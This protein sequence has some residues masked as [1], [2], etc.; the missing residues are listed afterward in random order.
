MWLIGRTPALH[1]QGT[2]FKLAF[3]QPPPL[4]QILPSHTYG[5]NNRLP[6]QSPIPA[7][8]PWICT[9]TFPHKQVPYLP[10]RV[11]RLGLLLPTEASGPTSLLLCAELRGSMWWTPSTRPNSSNRRRTSHCP[12][13]VPSVCPTLSL[14]DP[15]VQSQL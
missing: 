3:A 10:G 6:S 5:L 8:S 15:Q 9:H 4:R 12:G 14:I 2:N 13:I 11:H 7:S 1:E